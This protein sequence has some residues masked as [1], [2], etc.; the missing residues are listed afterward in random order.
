MTSPIS[1]QIEAGHF[2]CNITCAVQDIYTDM[3]TTWTTPSTIQRTDIV[4]FR[5]AAGGAGGC[6]FQGGGGSGGE[7]SLDLTNL[8]PG[9]V[10]QVRVGGA[11]RGSG[12]SR[13]GNTNGGH[14]SI[15]YTDP[16]TP[17]SSYTY[18]A[19]GGEIDNAQGGGRGGQGCDP[20]S[21]GCALPRD[22]A[23]NGDPNLISCSFLPSGNG[24]GGPANIATGNAMGSC[25]QNTRNG[26]GRWGAGGGAVGPSNAG[27]PNWQWG[28]DGYQGC[29]TAEIKP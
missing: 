14:S 9:V 2:P 12:A 16:N 21:G 1:A 5:I 15:T 19:N 28:F 22:Q 3:V 6:P 20:A 27:D 7:V 10:F 24:D 18:S 29:V 13:S 26:A 4:H 17:N 11:G 23:Q 25:G 8:P